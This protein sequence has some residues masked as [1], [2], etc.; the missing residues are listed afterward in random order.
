MPSKPTILCPN[1]GGQHY[2]VAKPQNFNEIVAEFLGTFCFRCAKCGHHFQHSVFG[3][4]TVFYAKCPRCFRMDLTTWSESHYRPT[5]WTK[6][7]IALGA[8]R[9]RCEGCRCN[10]VSFRGRRE[11]YVRRE[12]QPTD[13][14]VSSQS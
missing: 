10:F 12:A 8:K 3:R 13:P 4:E 5:W 11:K 14:L 9:L 1:C 6:L 2:R 7:Q